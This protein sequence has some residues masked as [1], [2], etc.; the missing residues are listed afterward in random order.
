MS[1]STFT[2]TKD[3][4]ITALN[5]LV[6]GNTPSFGKIL[7]STTV[8]VTFSDN[9]S[10]Q[11]SQ[12]TTV[13]SGNTLTAYGFLSITDSKTVATVSLSLVVRY[14]YG[15]STGNYTDITATGVISG[16]NISLNPGIYLVR[17]SA[18]LTPTT[19]SV[20]L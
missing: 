14:Q 19:A 1:A 3:P 2:V 15:G 20:Y 18:T 6:S 12:A 7:Q 8:S 13:F 4:Y 11:L 5:T 16:L 9:T 10:A 17:V